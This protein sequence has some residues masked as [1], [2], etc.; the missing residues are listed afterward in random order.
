MNVPKTSPISLDIS[1][2]IDSMDFSTPICTSERESICLELANLS[3]EPDSLK[4]EVEVLQMKM[5]CKY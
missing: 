5:L 3:N 4:A 1:D 2:T